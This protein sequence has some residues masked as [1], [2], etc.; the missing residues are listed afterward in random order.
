MESETDSEVFDYVDDDDNLSD[1]ST[2]Y[3]SESD[4]EEGLMKLSLE[5]EIAAL[6][7][8]EEHIGSATEKSYQAKDGSWRPIPERGTFE[9]F[10]KADDFNRYNFQPPSNANQAYF[11]SLLLPNNLIQW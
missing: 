10:L 1:D 8:L 2:L 4:I 11:W 6:S 5:E 3:D 7:D 9:N